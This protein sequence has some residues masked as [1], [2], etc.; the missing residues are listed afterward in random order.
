MCQIILI[1]ISQPYLWVTTTFPIGLV[2]IIS[3]FGLSDSYR[4]LIGLLYHNPKFTHS[5]DDSLKKS[6]GSNHPFH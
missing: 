1:S 6:F 4:Q 5:Q 3:I 2:Q